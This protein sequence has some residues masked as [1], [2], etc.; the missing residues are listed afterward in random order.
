MKGF[1]MGFLVGFLRAQNVSC[2]PCADSQREL[3][4]HSTETRVNSGCTWFPT[5]ETVSTRGNLK[6]PIGFLEGCL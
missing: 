6:F 1:P 4:K 3:R 2:F 5:V